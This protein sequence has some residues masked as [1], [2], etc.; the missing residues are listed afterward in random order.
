MKIPAPFKAPIL[1][2]LLLSL[3]CEGGA[4]PPDPAEIPSASESKSGRL[5]IVGGALQSENTPVYQAVLDGR[6]DGGPLCVIPT[7]SGT[8][9]RSMEGYVTAFNELG[10]A[11]TARGV[12]ITVDD[13]SRATDQSLRAELEACGGFFF[14]GGSQSRIVEVFRPGGETT[15]ALEAVKNRWR[16]GAV[17]AGSSAGAAIMTDPMIA[18]GSS[19][20]ALR[21]GVRYDEEGEGVWLQRGLGFLEMG[22]MDQH[23]LAR[24]RW[25][26]L[27]VAVLNGQVGGIGFGIDENTALVVDGNSARVVGESGVIF[28]DARDASREEAGTGGYGIRLYLLGKGDVVLLDEGVVTWEAGKAS[29]PQSGEPFSPDDP[30]LFARFNFL[31]VLHDLARSPDPR[32]TLSQGDHLVEL[33]KEAGFNVLSLEGEGIAGTPNGL[34]LGPLILSVWRQ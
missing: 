31:K 34:S 17:V 7:A 1:S 25:G 27:V 5:V 28:L 8:P 24:G 22:V 19:D 15:P 30:D 11:E 6:L 10:G 26:R 2:L 3:A 32:V 29:I 12:L 4:P 33:R 21:V 16:A 20:A 14:T 18:G 23:F 9:E 13:P